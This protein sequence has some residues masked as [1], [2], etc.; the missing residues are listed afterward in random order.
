MA[1]PGT[2]GLAGIDGL[3]DAAV[4][5]IAGFAIVPAI[6]PAAPIPALA[7]SVWPPAP[8]GEFDLRLAPPM[9]LDSKPSCRS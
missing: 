2:A 1:F 5:G 7:S 3:G 4:P 9:V 8:R 6:V